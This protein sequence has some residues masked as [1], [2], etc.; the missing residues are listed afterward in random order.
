MVSLF[1]AYSQQCFVVYCV[2]ENFVVVVSNIDNVESHVWELDIVS[3][4]FPGS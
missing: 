4:P 2:I 3:T 1:T